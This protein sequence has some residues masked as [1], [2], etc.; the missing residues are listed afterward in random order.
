MTELVR[1]SLI[2]RFRDPKV[3]P[4]AGSGFHAEMSRFS[5]G[6]VP[7]AGLERGQVGVPG[8]LV[9]GVVVVT[10]TLIFILTFA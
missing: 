10:L 5:M 7:E 4:G 1:I 9:P 6:P 3:L 8:R 2:I